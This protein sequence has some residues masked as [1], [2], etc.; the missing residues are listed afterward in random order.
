MRRN[1]TNLLIGI[2]SGLV[3]GAVSAIMLAPTSGSETRN[4][5]KGSMRRAKDVA[6]RREPAPPQDVEKI[7][8]NTAT[9]TELMRI[10]GIG[11]SSAREIIR[12]REEHGG[13]RSVDEL[14]EVYGFGEVMAN[15]VRSRVFVG[16]PAEEET[17]VPPEA[18]NI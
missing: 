4:R 10:E 6:R 1:V 3:A 16:E 11:P 15:K 7:D 8:L 2:A 17:P 9:A 12:Y 5:I 14:S 18:M 13:F